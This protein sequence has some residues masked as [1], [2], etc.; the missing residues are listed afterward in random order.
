MK[1][2]K[3]TFFPA[4]FLVL[5]V[6]FACAGKPRGFGE[7]TELFVVADPETWTAVEP[8]LRAAFERAINTPAPEYVFQI[9]HVPPGRFNEFATRK[10]L[11]IV[12]ILGSEG[13]ISQKVSN[14]L[15]SGVREKVEDGSA[16]VFPKDNPWADEQLLL[17]LAGASTGELN[18]KLAENKDY[19]YG[20]L[21]KRLLSATKEE[22]FAQLEQKKLEA[23]LL[24][25]YGWT[26]RIQHDYY[27]N[28][29]R[30]DANFVMLRRSLP[31]RE[32]WIFVHWI[33]DADPE[34][35]D[36]EWVLGNRDALTSQFYKGAEG[37]GDQI[38]RDEQYL[39]F[40][41][42]EF[43]GRNALKLEGLWENIHE[44]SGGGGPFRNY[45]FYD[46]TTGRIYM[47]DISVFYPGGPKEPFLRQLDVM[48]HS[49]KTAA[50]V[51][52]ENKEES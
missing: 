48:A 49:F 38:Y 31:G 28:I 6:G 19:L 46:E 7:S 22:M 15:S 17:V 14:M 43:A 34:V 13:E 45:T 29:E 25:K 39:T 27:V 42:V 16:F 4:V 33:E 44:S 8:G 1:I 35:M 18:Q 52:K 24:E 32:R 36:N 40:R 37:V 23:E 47:I 11:A 5:T 3:N 26:L 2:K 50:D 21:E 30:R 41:N 51:T 9:F 12:G 10:N 20:L